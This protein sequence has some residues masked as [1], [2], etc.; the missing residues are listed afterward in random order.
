MGSAVD[1]LHGMGSSICSFSSKVR[2]TLQVTGISQTKTTNNLF[3]FL[4]QFIWYNYKWMNLTQHNTGG[5]NE[6][7]GWWGWICVSKECLSLNQCTDFLSI[8]S[9]LQVW[10]YPSNDII[11]SSFLPSF[12][13]FFFL[14]LLSI[15]FDDGM[16]QVKERSLKTNI[17]QWNRRVTPCWPN[18]TNS[19]DHPSIWLILCL[20]LLIT[21]RRGQQCLVN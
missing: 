17:S 3:I 8:L 5:W 16:G 13:L 10:T 11:M 2:Y 9:A 14:M 18:S 21:T 4:N 20:H 6:T 1:V 19:T 7:V 12:H 15:S